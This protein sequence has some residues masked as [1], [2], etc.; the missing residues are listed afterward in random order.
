MEVKD[1]MKIVASKRDDIIRRRDEYD[2]KAAERQAKYDEQYKR[3][4]TDEKAVYDEVEA[5]VLANIP[6]ADALRI[7]VN[8]SRAIFEGG[9]E[10]HI[11]SN[12]F[13]GDDNVALKWDWKIYLS[14][15]GEMK[16]ESNSWSGLNACTAEQLQSLQMTLDALKAINEMPWESILSKTLPEY[17]D[18]ITD[19][20]ANRSARPN[21]EQ[22]LIEADIEEAI[23]NGSWIKGHGY[24]WYRKSATVYYKVLKATPKQYE[25]DEV[26]EGYMDKG[27]KSSPYKVT[28]EVFFQLIDKPLQIWE[29]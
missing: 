4:K 11:Y 21:F 28:K 7:R 2:A 15:L 18:Y 26:Y 22:E 13:G 10:V 1:T 19:S 9:L 14:K 3:Y 29:G 23:E 25:V 24:K 17:N 27:I 8:V 20:P 12:E 6:N 16:K 5:E